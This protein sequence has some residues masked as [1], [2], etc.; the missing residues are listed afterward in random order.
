MFWL[1]LKDIHH[2]TG[3]FD[4][5][6]RWLT[7]TALVGKYHVYHEFYSL[8]YTGVLG[9]I[10]GRVC[11]KPLDIGPFERSWDDVKNT[12]NREAVTLGGGTDKE[13]LRFLYYCQYP[14]RKD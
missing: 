5:E 10:A 3:P 9:F 1:E 13:A 6:A 7:N 11:S 8:P 4:K 14:K 2:K 12:K